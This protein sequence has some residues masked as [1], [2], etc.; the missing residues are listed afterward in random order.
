M[1]RR[2][3]RRRGHAAATS[4]M[5]APSLRKSQLE[6]HIVAVGHGGQ[7]KLNPFGAATRMRRSSALSHGQPVQSLPR[8][9]SL[10]YTTGAVAALG[11]FSRFG[12]HGT[13]VDQVAARAGSRRATCCTTS[14]PRRSSPAAC[15][16]T[17]PRSGRPN[18]WRADAQPHRAHRMFKQGSRAPFD[19]YFDALGSVAIAQ[20]WQALTD[21]TSR[22]RDDRRTARGDQADA[23]PAG[24]DPGLRALV[25]SVPA[26]PSSQMR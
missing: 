25:R 23:L 8:C 5:R 16:A 18:R 13:S 21:E 20:R 15:C 24:H 6:M 2:A 9:G 22:A 17:C 14:R 11:L 26:E 10:P 1:V 12:L 3:A 4:P 7:A 19:R